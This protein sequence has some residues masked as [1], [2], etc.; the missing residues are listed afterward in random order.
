MSDKY[1]GT[2]SDQA[3]KRMLDA[4]NVTYE[5]MKEIAITIRSNDSEET[6]F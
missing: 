5:K 3:A 6:D 2:E 4:A 1:S